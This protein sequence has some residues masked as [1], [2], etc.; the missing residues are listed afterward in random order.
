MIRGGSY[1]PATGVLDAA[2]NSGDIR[3]IR[4]PELRAALAEWPATVDNLSNVEAIVDTLVFGQMVPW[5]RMQ[6]ALPNNSFAEFGIPDARIDTDYEFLASSVV[7]EN[8]L[9]EEIA[10]GRIP[11]GNR[12]DLVQVIDKICTRIRENLRE[13]S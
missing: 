3:V 2:M 6:T 4:D 9:R 12:N 5:V 1:D 8:F 7:M 11:D 10:W 13:D